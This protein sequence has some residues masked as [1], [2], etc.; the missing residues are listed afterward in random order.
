M[1]INQ[2]GSLQGLSA[3]IIVVEEINDMYGS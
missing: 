2:C 3:N 1:C